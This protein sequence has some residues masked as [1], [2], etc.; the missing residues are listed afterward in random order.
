M[1][2][3]LIKINPEQLDPKKG[4][5]R[6]KPLYRR[7]WVHVLLILLLL[8][9]L[10]GW[11]GLKAYLKP[12]E[13]KAETYDMALVP[14][15]EQ[16]STIY[17]RNREEIGR[18]ANE[19]RVI[20]P[21]S[22]MPKHLID[23]LIA[24]EDQRFWEHD[25]VDYMGILRAAKTNFFAG[26][27]KQGA[28]TITQQLARN[29]YGLTEKTR[30]RKILEMYLARRLEKHYKKPQILEH[31][32][33]RIPLGKGFYGIEAAA[34]GYFSKP[35]KDLTVSE[36]AVL[37]G[38]IKSPTFFN[39]VRDMKASTR[40]RN[41][42]F[43]RM[44]DE[45]KLDEDEAEKLK[46]QSIVLRLSENTRSTGYA[47]SDV[48]DEV[49]AI[50]AGLGI[51]GITGKGYKIFTTLDRGLQQAAEKSLAQRLA[52]IENS[53]GYPERE[54]MS[55]YSKRLAEY[56]AALEA[57]QKGTGPEPKEKPVPSYLQGALL[58]VDNRTGGVLAMCGGRD[59][60]QSQFNRV[61]HS[62][63]PAGTVFVP[64]VYTAAFEGVHFP[65]SRIT[66]QRMDNTKVMMGAVTGTLG[67]WGMEVTEG[68]H[69]GTTSL[70]SAFIQ[71]KN[72][73][74]ARLGLEI[75]VDK[76]T[77][78][79]RRAGLGEMPNDPSTLLGRA[80]VSLRDLTLAYSA[81]PNGGAK[82]EGIWFVSRIEKSDG[83]VIYDRP[84]EHRLTPVTDP[85]AAWMT[86]SCLED[87][88]FSDIGTASNYQSY[89]PAMKDLHV[90]GKTG[91]HLNSTDLWFAGYSK[92]ITCAVWVGLDKRDTVYPDAF[93]RHAALP[94]WVDVMLASAEK[95]APEA[96]EEPKGVQLVE[97][98]AESGELATDACLETGPD[99][100]DP[101]RT[102]LI[103]C[104]YME[105]IRPTSKW[106]MR[107]T[108][109]NK[110]EIAASV[111]A[112]V[113]PLAIASGSTDP[114]LDNRP[115]A[116]SAQVV[117]GE[118]PYNSITGARVV[119]GDST[120]GPVTLVPTD[121]TGPPL[122]PAA[123]V[124]NPGNSAL[125]N[126]SPGKATVD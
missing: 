5:R 109:H 119:P 64:F 49:D 14:Q 37:V 99:P 16:N 55:D 74:A 116:L 25:G 75:G 8:T 65:G 124:P 44:V 21:F 87:T 34:Q 98:C 6:K 38:L 42:V 4:K 113:N 60:G 22:D 20:I 41:K 112:P 95:K 2:G 1:I 78:L 67:E 17:D 10:G 100:A 3:D 105:F 32:L 51:E 77:D 107:C 35:A 27:A 56:T 70:R 46:G 31:Y 115:L 120:A 122:I 102:K 121:S 19:N 66:D 30:E 71:G 79:A 86:H 104:S 92:D 15:F 97:L 110:N 91:T 73:C 93:S 24:T 26:E 125:L 45:G 7:R 69:E 76:V 68:E 101:T 43:E 28:S 11:L 89:G 111:T 90:A 108:F 126:P 61:L 9:G 84:A 96:L 82:P 36:A 114:G 13:E 83:T 48:E 81:F 88:V 23:A 80:E 62:K 39:P 118:D 72:N 94:V 85:I 52:E 106:E 54:K 12:F 40:E 59:Y 33:N 18:L 29:T 63:R 123:P 53:Q 57:F 103:K 50:L 47:Q 58:A 117:V